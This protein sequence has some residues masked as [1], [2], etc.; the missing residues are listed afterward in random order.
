MFAYA[1]I[2]TNQC[3]GPCKTLNT[4]Y[5][6]SIDQAVELMFGDRRVASRLVARIRVR[7][8]RTCHRLRS[9]ATQ[10]AWCVQWT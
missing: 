1:E 2:L 8:G 3:G 4:C 10:A 5:I 7:G 6:T 9:I